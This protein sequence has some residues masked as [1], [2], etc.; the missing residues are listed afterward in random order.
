MV[1]QA[2]EDFTNYLKSRGA[3][4]DGDSAF[5]KNQEQGKIGEDPKTPQ[6]AG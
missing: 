2:I 4:S 1:E 3:L 5:N 6:W